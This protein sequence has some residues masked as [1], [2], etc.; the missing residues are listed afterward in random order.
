MKIIDHN[1][2]FAPKISSSKIKHKSKYSIN[3]HIAFNNQQ[4][5]LH[6]CGVWGLYGVL[7]LLLS[8]SSTQSLQEV[9]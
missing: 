6:M 3:K 5:S 9:F 1:I 7:V 2:K 4:T 8:E